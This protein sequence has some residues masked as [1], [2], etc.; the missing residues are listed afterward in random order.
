KRTPHHVQ[1]LKL[2]EKLERGEIYI[3]ISESIIT[4]LIYLSFHSHKI[5]HALLKIQKFV[6]LCRVSSSNKNVILQ[7]MN[8]NFK[9]KEDAIQYHIALH[10]GLDYF[11]SRN[12]KD[13]QGFTSTIPVYTPQT[14]IES[15]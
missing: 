9:D 2:I 3:H 15:F 8:S 12:I 11:I 13:Y 10:N 5:D 4:N 7:A 6:D 14:F 1:S